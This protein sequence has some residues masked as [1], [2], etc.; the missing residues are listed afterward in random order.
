MATPPTT[1]A[2]PAQR[3]TTTPSAIPQPID[4][5]NGY[6]IV[7]ISLANQFASQIAAM[8]YPRIAQAAQLTAVNQA[9]QLAQQQQQQ[10][11]PPPI[12]Q[13]AQTSRLCCVL[14][15]RFEFDFIIPFKL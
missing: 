1:L 8:I 6:V 15:F 7:P 9:A 11:V 10:Q 12:L 14:R 3:D 5:G 2:T 13:P 4:L